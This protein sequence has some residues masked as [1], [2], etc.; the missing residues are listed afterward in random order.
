MSSQGNRA[1]S[2]VRPPRLL[3]VGAT[4]AGLRKFLGTYNENTHPLRV[5]SCHNEDAIRSAPLPVSGQADEA[6][7]A[8]VERIDFKDGH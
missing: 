5:P 4:S 7:L 3:G 1:F 6:H 2:G 8:L